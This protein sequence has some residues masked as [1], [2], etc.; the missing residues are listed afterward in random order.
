MEDKPEGVSH[1][2]T[3]NEQVVEEPFTPTYENPVQDQSSEPNIQPSNML[4]STIDLAVE[5]FNEIDSDHS[6]TIDLQKTLAWWHTNFAKINSHAMFESVDA[7]KDGKISLD[8]WLNFWQALRSHSH[9]DEEI[10]E[11]LNNLR[12]GNSWVVFQD[13]PRVS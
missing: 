12:Q 10:V 6:R 8:E 7:N 5:V 4:Q 11:E 3:F 1:R 13:M 2:V 9:L